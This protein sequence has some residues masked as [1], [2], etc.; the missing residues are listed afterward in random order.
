MIPAPVA[1]FDPLLLKALAIL[2]TLLTSIT[3]FCLVG[4]WSIQCLSFFS[5]TSSIYPSMYSTLT[6]IHLLAMIPAPVAKFDPLLLQALAILDTLLTSITPFCLVG[7]WSIQCL[8][9]F[10]F[11][12]SIY[13]SMYSTLTLIHLLAM[14]PAPVA[15]F[16]PLLLQ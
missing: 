15:K 16:D 8:S 3:P 12:S 6:L 4:H 2:D 11:T 7:H 5:F 14:I 9:F 1:K 13:P 10:S